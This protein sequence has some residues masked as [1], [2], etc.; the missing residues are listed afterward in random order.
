MVELEASPEEIKRLV[1]GKDQTSRIVSIENK[2]NELY[3][4]RQL[5]NGKLELTKKPSLFWFITNQ[6][7]SAKQTVLEG[8]QHYKYL[9]KFNS[10][11]ERDKV[12]GLCKKSNVDFYRI[13]NQKESALVYNGMT[14]YKGL[15]PKDITVLSF[16]IETSTL[17][18]LP[19]SKILMIT[20][21][22]RNANGL[23]IKKCFDLLTY[24]GDEKAMILA[25]IK[26]VRIVDPSIMLGH[27]I[28]GFDIPYF[29]F[30]AKQL[31]IWLDLGRDGSSINF[32]N[33]ASSFRKDGS[34]EIE[35]FNCHIFGREIL[36]TMFLSYQY[37]I[38]RSFPSYGLK[39]I[40]NYLGMEKKDRTFIDA[41]KIGKY[42][43]EALKGNLEMWNKAKDYANDD[44]D[45]AL[46][47]Y[48]IMI[49]AKFYFTQSVSKSF[50]YMGI[51]A[52]GSQINNIMVRS[53]LQEGY[54]IP[55]ADEASSFEGAI[56][57]G[58]A[59]IYKNCLKCDVSSLYPSL[60]RQYKVYN[61]D[62][63]PLGNF[64]K[65]TEYFATE[66]LKNKKLAKETGEQYYDDLQQSQKVAANSLYGFMGAPG[67]NFNYIEGAAFVTR[68]GREVLEKAVLFATNKN[69]NHW[70]ELSTHEE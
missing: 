43:E 4:Y 48:D 46:K 36:D 20:N 11:E 70:K 27:N 42:Y 63:D 64:L 33:W 66:R 24:K 8:H 60:M 53:Y 26:W 50:Q 56:S 12:V 59:G 6:R 55:K 57:F 35:Y 61:K 58:I 51:S 52:T 19:E 22:F 62:K 28:F 18:H 39:P 7:I 21:T 45:D 65:I 34:Q 49:P 16:D 44:S 15:N 23:L 40:V 32:D 5:E 2:D 54:S 1:F 69:I 38:G 13:Y 41:S 29:R 67:L 37:D 68:K 14:Y 9:A 10:Q 17:R 25:W 3:I 30:R 47:L 31:G